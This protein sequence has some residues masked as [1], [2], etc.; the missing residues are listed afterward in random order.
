M[1]VMFSRPEASD[2]KLQLTS[3]HCGAWDFILL[4]AL[5]YC[6]L[7]RGTTVDDHG[8]YPQRTTDGN[9]GYAVHDIIDA[10]RMSAEDAAAMADALERHCTVE[11]R[12][13][14]NLAEFGH[15]VPTDDNDPTSPAKIANF[16]TFL[17]AGALKFYA[18]DS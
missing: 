14:A 11:L 16:I 10:R 7:P 9:G 18:W 13:R 1:R 2:S 15:T 6:W 5:K 4:Q 12:R 17:R 8:F 3:F